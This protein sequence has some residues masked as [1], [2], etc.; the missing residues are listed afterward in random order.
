MYKYPIYINLKHKQA[1]FSLAMGADADLIS[2]EKDTA[3]VYKF[4]FSTGQGPLTCILWCR[5]QVPPWEVVT[6]ME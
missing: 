2:D 4:F 3:R 6:R 1:R 5:F